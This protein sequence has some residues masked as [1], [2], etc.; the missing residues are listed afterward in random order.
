[1]EKKF[2]L[3]VSVLITIL[4]FNTNGQT[5]SNTSPAIPKDSISVIIHNQKR[6]T[7]VLVAIN[8]TGKLY[9]FPPDNMPCLVPDTLAFDKMRVYK[10]GNDNMPNVIPERKVI[11]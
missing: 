6:D 1:M 5:I 3:M 8:G 2:T 11:P 4:F 7:A 10:K 9:K